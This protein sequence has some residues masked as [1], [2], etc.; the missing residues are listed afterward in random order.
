MLYTKLIFDGK[1]K[2]T[3][4]N[5]ENIIQ[6]QFNKNMEIIYIIIFLYANEKDIYS[7]ESAVNA[8]KQSLCRS[9]SRGIHCSLFI[10]G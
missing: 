3:I 7:F 6:N 9:F 8:C 5:N 2:N 4:N 1:I 10:S